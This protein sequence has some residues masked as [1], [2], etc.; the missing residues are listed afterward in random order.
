[1]RKRALAIFGGKRMPPEA[2]AGIEVRAKGFACATPQRAWQVLTD[3]ERL[4]EFV[5]N[6]TSSTLISRNGREAV[7]EQYG[8]GGFL[9]ITQEIHLVLRVREQPFSA[10]DITRIAG[11]MKRY[12]AQWILIP[13]RENRC[14]GTRIAYSAILQP[15]F[16]LPPFVGPALVQADV[17]KMLQAVLAEIER[18][19]HR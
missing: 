6:L 12:D 18:W 11:N 16:F 8:S 19:G 4:A 13:A 1:M 2:A 10:I 14:D 5:P 15:D 9:F 7:V 3:Y 17:E